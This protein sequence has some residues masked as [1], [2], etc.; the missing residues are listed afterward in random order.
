MT[1]P[2]A[3]PATPYPTIGEICQLVAEAFDTKSFDPKMR[4][5][6]DRLAREGDFDWSLRS[7]IIETLVT[8]PL[9]KRLG[10]E[11][12]DFIGRS[13]QFFL[14]EHIR[15][16]TQ[17]PADALIRGEVVSLLIEHADAGTLALT[18]TNLHKRIGGPDIHSL[19][20]H[21]DNPINAV[22]VWAE[23]VLKLDVPKTAF[24]DNKQKRDEIARWRRGKTLPGFYSSISPLIADL[25]KKLGE[26]EHRVLLF[27]K[28]LVVARA[29]AWAE[30]KS[31]KAEYGALLDLVRR[32]MKQGCPPRDIGAL[33]SRANIAAAERLTE[34]K[35]CGLW[36]LDDGLTRLHPKA[37]GDQAATRE[38]INR[39]AALTEKD[40]SDGRTRYFL[41]WCEARW[42]VL[43]G[44]EEKALAYYERAAN[45]ALYRAGSNQAEIL[46]EALAL[47]GYLRHMPA[48]KR[49]KHRAVAFGFFSDGFAYLPEKPGIV[50]DW[51]VDQFAQAFRRM[52]PP[53]CRFVEAAIR[54]GRSA[55]PFRMI[56]AAAIKDIK[57]DLS[58]PDRVIS[59]PTWDGEKYRR[60]QLIWFA[61]EGRA[62]E[63]RQLLEAGADVDISDE[64]GGSA[65]LCALQHA[66]DTGHRGALDLL[67][68]F[69]HVKETLERTTK[70][71]R[72]SPL[73]LAVLIGDFGIVARLLA[74]GADADLLVSDPPQ[75]PL[76]V[77]AERFGLL[78]RDAVKQQFLSRME[79]PSQGDKE[80]MRRYLG[81]MAG[82]FG[83]QIPRPD[84]TNPRHA[85]ILSE[86]A[87]AMIRGSQLP[88]EN[89]LKI[90]QL[91]LDHGADPNCAHA[92]PAPGRTPLMVAVE[93]DAVEAVRLLLKAGG[94]PFQQDAQGYDAL[95]LARGF[96]SRNV[97]NLLKETSDADTAQCDGATQ[98]G[99]LL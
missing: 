20:R 87:N 28:W 5:K 46:K 65:L 47:A 38:E 78:R 51:E 53:Q 55:L 27:G 29:L 98:S 24:P 2:I 31:G 92:R 94:N 32:E 30:R 82:V 57:P 89:L 25:K 7:E 56:D 63:V 76:Y 64:Q 18:L 73:Y 16:V 54:K 35:R 12:A 39:F 44:D 13:A 58:H 79:A 45:G 59:I 66:K 49:L 1:D 34:L 61:S 93:N 33:L 97:L 84:P 9:G 15:L 50:A 8:K 60:P 71:K 37:Q 42:R 90:M 14:D 81:G 11:F 85:A 6:L 80:I 48:I 67:L 62:D 36:L 68:Q 17:V 91:L 88:Y 75:T 52:F 10:R 83:D 72:L 77:C 43:S 86:V 99:A 40:A 3:Q 4:K 19:L 70:K 74:M 69:P 26:K 23:D 22:F 96:E 41:D 95:A 21:G